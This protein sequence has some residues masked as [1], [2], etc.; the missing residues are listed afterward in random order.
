MKRQYICSCFFTHNIFL[1]RYGL[2]V[3]YNNEQ[4][5][6][7]DYKQILEERGCNTKEKIQNV[8]ELIHEE[9][10]KRRSNGRE[11]RRRKEV[12]ACTYKPLYSQLYKLQESFLDARFCDIVNYAKET[13]ADRQQLVNMLKSW[14]APGTF[15]LPVFT[16][17]F[18]EKLVEE[19]K[20]YEQ[21]DAPKSRPNSMNCYGVLLDELGFYPNFINKLCK[22]YISPIARILY[23]E[24]CG[25]NGLDSHR[26]FVVSYDY[27][28]SKDDTGLDLHYDNAEVTLNVSLTDSF[29]EGDLYFSCM[30]QEQHMEYFQVL[31]HLGHGVLHRGQHMHGAM[32]LTSGERFNLIIWM[33]SSCVRN[34][35][36]PM[37]DEV[38]SLVETE[39]DGDGFTADDMVNVCSLT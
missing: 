1:K 24:W 15:T 21:S 36:C 22:Q 39:G 18:C 2:H 26:A 27:N 14:K 31:H 19:L 5:F 38:P 8:K 13:T 12:I 9:I 10:N 30:R 17:F 11:S 33:R 25:E 6:L 28:E 4:Q 3:T 7:S 37:C 29:D 20:H 23:P 16:R 34:Q 35:L 32:P